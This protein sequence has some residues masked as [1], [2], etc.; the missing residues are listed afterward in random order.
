[1]QSEH[2]Y[3]TDTEDSESVNSSATVKKPSAN[4]SALTKAN[5]SSRPPAEV[6]AFGT[7][8]Q[9]F[10]KDLIKSLS[11]FKFTEELTD[12]NYVSWSQAVSELF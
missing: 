7:D 12:G 4:S 10:S 3:P 8:L 5:M 11:N 2:E 6:R 1:M 9:K